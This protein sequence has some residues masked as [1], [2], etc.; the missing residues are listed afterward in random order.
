M[1]APPAV[2]AAGQ[3]LYDELGPITAGDEQL[4]YPLLR[5]CDAIAGRLLQAVDDLCRD[6]DDGPGWSQ[7]L[8][9]D[10][11][12]TEGITW[13]A[14][15]VGTQIDPAATED[16]QRAQILAESGFARGTP[17]AIIA[18]AQR[19]L[20]GAQTIQLVERD[21]NDPYLLT[22]VVYG[23]QVVGQSYGDLSHEYATYALLDGAFPTYADFASG[24]DELAVALEAAKPAGLVLNLVVGVGQ[25]YAQ[26]SAETWGS[27]YSA[28][29]SHY[30]TYS[31]M[32]SAPP[33]T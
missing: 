8:D 31:A 3:L 26:L 28:T 11:V 5:F 19:Y 25:T 15:F 13:L 9:P 29:T 27:T 32:T 7:L 24:A 16:A 17:A 30:G 10:R 22:V 33:G 4:G 23:S 1:T 2:T 12:P 21:A 6:T 14:Q 18:A 20:T